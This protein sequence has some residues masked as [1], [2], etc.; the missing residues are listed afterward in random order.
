MARSLAPLHLARDHYS[1][2]LMREHYLGLHF[3]HV[4]SACAAGAGRLYLDIRRVYLDI[5]TIVDKR[6]S[7]YRCERSMPPCI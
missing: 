5:D 4:L 1:R 6:E 3:I 2:R 7:K